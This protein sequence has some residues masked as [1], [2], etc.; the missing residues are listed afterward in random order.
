MRT[1]NVVYEERYLQREAQGWKYAYVHKH[2]WILRIR[3]QSSRRVRFAR[4]RSGGM[5]RSDANRRAG[6]GPTG[7][8]FRGGG[9]GVSPVGASFHARWLAIIRIDMYWYVV[10]VRMKRA[11]NAISQCWYLFVYVCWKHQ[12]I[13]PS[14]IVNHQY[15]VQKFH[16]FRLIF[17]LF[18]KGPHHFPE[19]SFHRIV[20]LPKR[21]IAE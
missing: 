1:W 12:M 8:A 2:Q 10:H 3:S 14:T 15:E 11:S 19:T 5:G 18:F 17:H 13:T 20:V 6:N 21:H 16:F 4:N 9:G 7:V